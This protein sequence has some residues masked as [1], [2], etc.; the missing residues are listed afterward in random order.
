MGAAS[1]GG[2]GIVAPGPRSSVG[3]LSATVGAGARAGK[4]P[5]A[6][7]YASANN[8]RSPQLKPKPGVHMQVLSGKIWNKHPKDGTLTKSNN[9]AP[10][11]NHDD[12]RSDFAAGS[13]KPS[14]FAP[15]LDGDRLPSQISNG[16]N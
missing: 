4:A 3:G 6:P 15:H 7:S 11:S 5:M 12:I 2:G 16:D 14:Y 1:T 10:K 13:K 9:A 8:S